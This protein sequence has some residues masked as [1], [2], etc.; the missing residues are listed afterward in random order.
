M[1]ARIQTWFPFHVQVGINGREWL[2]RQMQRAGLGYRQ[3]G[4][5]KETKN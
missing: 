5:H 4:N 1:H 2:T 3:G